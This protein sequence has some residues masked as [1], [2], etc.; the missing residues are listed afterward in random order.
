MNIQVK[1]NF[2]YYV[3]YVDDFIFGVGGSKKLAEEI[4][5]KIDSF[6]ISDFNLEVKRNQLVDHNGHA[7]KFLGF[8]VYF[9]KFRR[10]T[11]VKNNLSLLA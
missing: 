10:K 9:F 4:R 1:T 11:K 5:D 7:V 2:I 3:C 8:F 6:L